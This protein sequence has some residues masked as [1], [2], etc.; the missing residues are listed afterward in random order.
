MNP[1]QSQ[2][3]P[4]A[5][6][7]LPIAARKG[8]RGTSETEIVAADGSFLCDAFTVTEAAFIVRACNSHAALVDCLRS[9]QDDIEGDIDALMAMEEPAYHLHARVA[10]IRAALKLATLEATQ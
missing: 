6:F 4:H 1:T 2:P 9:L 5:P 3:N 8:L 10:A 7:P